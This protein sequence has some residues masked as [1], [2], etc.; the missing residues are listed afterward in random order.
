MLIMS[1]VGAPVER[2]K[3]EELAYL[4]VSGKIKW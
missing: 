3:R 1:R 2:V 4:F